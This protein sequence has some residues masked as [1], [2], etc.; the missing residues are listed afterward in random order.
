MPERIVQTKRRIK[1]EGERASPA[2]T[3]SESNGY[4][5][6]ALLLLA[7][8]CGGAAIAATTHMLI[9]AKQASIVSPIGQ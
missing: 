8:A 9:E 7:L 5:W 3:R 2:P 1:I 4:L 6:M